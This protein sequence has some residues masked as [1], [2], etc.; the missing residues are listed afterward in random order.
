MG[1]AGL[2]H[3]AFGQRWG[4]HLPISD[5]AESVLSFG[6]VSLVLLFSPE[7][8]RHILHTQSACPN[9]PCGNASPNICQN[10]GVKCRE[11][12]LCGTQHNLGNAAVMGLIPQV[13]YVMLSDLLLESMTDLQ[14]QAV[15]AHEL[16][17]VKHRHL[18]WFAMFFLT[19]SSCLFALWRLWKTI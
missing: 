16:G 6:S 5:T 19:V 14:I 10:A 3:T 1:I 17:H 9:P 8:L 11:I 18:A 13:R 7:L 15:F 2:S 12:L 4:L